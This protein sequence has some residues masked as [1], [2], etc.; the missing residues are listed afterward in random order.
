L[1]VSEL[2]FLFSADTDIQA[3]YEFYE[4]YQEGRGEVRF[5]PGIIF[6]SSAA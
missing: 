5:P 3:A 6:Q 2:V 4:A 1:A